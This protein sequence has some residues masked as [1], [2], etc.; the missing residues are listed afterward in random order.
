MAHEYA[1]KGGA[2]L[3]EESA[4]TTFTPAWRARA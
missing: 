1:I 2:W 3:L 4:T